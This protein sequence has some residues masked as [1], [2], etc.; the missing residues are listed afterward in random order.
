MGTY[1]DRQVVIIRT[2]Q[3]MRAVG[4]SKTGESWKYYPATVDRVAQVAR[5]CI[6]A[7]MSFTGEFVDE[8]GSYELIV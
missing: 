4:F 6:K 1:T 5:A 2:P 3:G 7:R 8:T